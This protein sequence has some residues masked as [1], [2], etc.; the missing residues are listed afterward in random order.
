[1]ASRHNEHR[2][3]YGKTFAHDNARVHLG[4]VS[5]DVNI[6]GPVDGGLHLHFHA[7]PA[8]LSLVAVI[9]PLFD[10]ASSLSSLATLLAIN[11]PRQEHVHELPLLLS[12]LPI[13]EFQLR[14]SCVSL[15]PHE[16]LSNTGQVRTIVFTV[17]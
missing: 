6:Q 12:R 3:S 2:K 7:S 10:F 8:T 16:P 14:S 9:V 17:Q 4:D 1:M 5:Q 13:L 15:Q 11:P